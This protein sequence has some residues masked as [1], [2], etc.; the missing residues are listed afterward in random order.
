MWR[1]NMDTE[2]I[3]FECHW[4]RRDKTRFS[5]VPKLDFNYFY[6]SILPVQHLN[7]LQREWRFHFKFCWIFLFTICMGKSY[8]HWNCKRNFIPVEFVQEGRWNS[9]NWCDNLIIS[10]KDLSMYAFYVTHDFEFSS[11][12]TINIATVYN[13]QINH[14]PMRYK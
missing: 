3:S 1:T 2:C 6:L 10:K 4:E 7:A 11:V 9:S 13:K 12:I 5:F 8:S 14:I